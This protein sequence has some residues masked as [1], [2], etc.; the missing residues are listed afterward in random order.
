MANVHALSRLQID[1]RSDS[2]SDSDESKSQIDISSDSSSSSSWSLSS[3]SL[4][5]DIRDDIIDKK[6]TKKLIKTKGEL[7]L[8]DLPPIENLSISVG[9]EELSQLGRVV[10]IVDQ[11]VNVQSFRSMPALDLDSVL[12]FKDG[13]PLGRIFDVFGP[14][15]E[16]R[17]SVRFNSVEE[18]IDRKISVETP[19]YFAAEQN[20][21][22]TGFVF[23]E[24]LRRMKGSDASWKHNNEPPEEAIEFSDDESERLYKQRLNPKRSY[25][26]RNF[27]QRQNPNVFSFVPNHR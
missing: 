15:V 23:A 2:D 20:Q 4:P 9:V 24:Q 12:F 14:V 6:E 7:S 5:D 3:D 13:T 21:P 16:P 10:S 17:Y 27:T 22:I 1:Y 18:I 11:L 25:S 19:V 26:R 8:E